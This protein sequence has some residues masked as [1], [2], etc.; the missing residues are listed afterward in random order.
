M[1]WVA[2]LKGFHAVGEPWKM[3]FQYLF[4]VVAVVAID[5]GSRLLNVLLKFKLMN[6]LIDSKI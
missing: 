2:N 3:K 4:E 6:Q 1:T 5:L